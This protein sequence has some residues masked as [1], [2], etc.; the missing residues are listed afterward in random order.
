MAS[1]L[2][3]F[4]ADDTEKLEAM[5]ICEKLGLNLQ[6]YLKMCLSRLV[7]E[8]GIPFSMHVHSRD[9][10]FQQA[11]DNAA[12]RAEE[13]GIADMTLEEINAEIAEARKNL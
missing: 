12:R 2:I 8:K 1:T 6:S 9:T 4:R 7:Q 3:Q 10:L 13:L 11:M 5:A